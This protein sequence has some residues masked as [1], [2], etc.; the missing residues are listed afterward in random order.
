METIRVAPYVIACNMQHASTV[1]TYPGSCKTCF[2][3]IPVY[4]GKV[5]LIFLI[6]DLR[7]DLQLICILLFDL[8]NP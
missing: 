5:S 1:L 4:G 3:H 6:I 2:F 8:F 7:V